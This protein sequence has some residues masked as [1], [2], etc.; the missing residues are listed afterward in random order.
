MKLGTLQ[1]VV[2]Q[3]LSTVF[4]VASEL[5]F[6]GVELDWYDF[7]EAQT[8]GPLAPENRATIQ[9][10]ASRAGVEIPSVAAHFLNHGGLADTEKEGFG[11]DAVRT[12]I[13]LCT[14]LGATFLLVPFFGPAMMTDE[15]AVSRLEK[16][17]RLL[18]PE[19]EAAGVTLAIEHTLRGDETAAL[20]DRVD[21]SSIGDYWDMANCMGLGYD[22]LEE[23]A[24][25]GRHIVRVHAKEYHQGGAPPGTPEEP[26]FDG[27][28]TKPFGQ[29][30]VP[31]PAVLSA[32]QQ[33]GYDGYVVLE[34]GK[35]DDA[36]RSAKAA[37]SLLQALTGQVP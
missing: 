6:E 28:N 19:A 11:L 27:L 2:E 9:R 32:L 30:D 18:A 26:H 24:Q 37:L 15:E 17:L 36:R 35:F 21:S 10:A 3:P 8:G 7:A 34:T 13:G 1:N 23:I 16:N 4:A 33:N 12:G 22:P 29:G 14:D 25:L 31:V 20:L 5:G